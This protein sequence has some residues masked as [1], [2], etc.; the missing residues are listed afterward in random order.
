MI[1]VT[2]ANMLATLLGVVTG[3]L[4]AHALGPAG[5]GTLAA[6]L[7]PIAVA[8]F[9]IDLG[10]TSYATRACARG[11]PL[12]TLL[13]SLGGASFALGAIGAVIGYPVALL[14]ANGRNVVFTFVLIG[15]LLLPLAICASVLHAL[16]IGLERWTLVILARLAPLVI[17][18][19]C[20]C[21]LFAFDR[22]SVGTAAAATIG[23]G[24]LGALPL[25]NLVRGVGG[26][27]FRLAVVQEGL[28][29]GSKAWIGTL[30]SL[31]NLRLDQLL[32]IPLVNPRQLG[33]YVVAVT[34]AGLP[35]VLTG[36]VSHVVGP[37]VARD[38]PAL[39]TQAL[40]ATLLVATI[41]SLALAA[42][43]PWL[44][45]LAFGSP[46]RDAL[47]MTWVLLLAGVPAQGLI[48]LGS[49]LIL[50]G[51]PGASTLAQ[52]VALGITLPG[53]VILLPLLGGLG[54]ALVSLAAYSI[55]FGV[56]VVAARRRFGASLGDLLIP[57]TRD[58]VLLKNL[59][60]SFTL[61]LLRRS[62]RA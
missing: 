6:I 8:P 18:L 29:F 41:A 28:I 30:S 39:A 33:L 2:V 54:A 46:F 16:A 40:R 15:F 13:G 4:L 37:R 57:K 7:V 17:V 9:I 44:V 61:V 34:V 58:L 48:L 42:A 56:L 24:V 19:V 14:L 23:G 11:R 52:L 3:P 55:S 26:I 50:A 51:S 38:D 12:G 49:M 22:L 43:A 20:V 21:G 27:A 10:L 5:R 45:P 35:A 47:A 1:S 62:A 36:A 32:M 25:L 60:R 31:A 53:L 59:L